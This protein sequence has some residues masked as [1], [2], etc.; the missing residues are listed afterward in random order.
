MSRNAILVV[1]LAVAYSILK[2]QSLNLSHLWGLTPKLLGGLGYDPNKL[3]QIDLYA[4]LIVLSLD[5]VLPPVILNGLGYA[6]GLSISYITF[7]FVFSNLWL[8]SRLSNN[9]IAFILLLLIYTV[10][11]V[12]LTVSSIAT[13][14]LMKNITP[15]EFQ[16]RII[17]VTTC[18]GYAVQSIGHIGTGGFFAWSLKNLQESH[19]K[20]SFPLNESFTFYLISLLS[21]VA[22]FTALA[23]PGSVE[24]ALQ[25]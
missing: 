24:K 22:A 13:W 11:R 23:F 21:L 4:S 20:I 16:G 5:I 6:K 25:E 1:F 8:T 12:A 17:T 10:S 2:D 9:T 18:L 15:R 19:G 3:G 7:A 14:V